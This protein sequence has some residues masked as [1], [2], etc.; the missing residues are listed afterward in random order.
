MTVLLTS[1]L[2]GLEVRG[3][4]PST[5]QELPTT[6]TRLSLDRDPIWP[7]RDP[8][9]EAL[10]QV[11]LALA[12]A[13]S[14]LIQVALSPDV[15]WQSR[16]VRQLDQMAGLPPEPNFFTSVLGW[17]V[18]SAFHLV[19]PEAPAPPAE[20]RRLSKPA[21]PSE[22]AWRPGFRSDIPLRIS[23]PASGQAKASMHALVAAFRAFD[24]AN[25]F[26]PQR[27][28]LARR[29]EAPRCFKWVAGS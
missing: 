20:P 13:P 18:D 4:E 15:G 8:R 21:P 14:G 29:F 12:A 6:R 27:V 10:R 17:L 25:G 23:A 28:W 9:P 22:K 3:S 24:G 16:A 1:A 2:P 7:L 26:R 19:L 11:I 5:S